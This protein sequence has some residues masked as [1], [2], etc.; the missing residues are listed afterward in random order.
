[1][2]SDADPGW[3][4]NADTARM[5]PGG[6]P[7]VPPVYGE[8]SAAEG[9]AAAGDTSAPA[10]RDSAAGSSAAVSGAPAAE[11]ADP[12]REA[13]QAALKSKPLGSSLGLTLDGGGDAE[14]SVVAAPS[15]AEMAAAAEREAA[16]RAPG[17]VQT[18][19]GGGLQGEVAT[20]S[21]YAIGASGEP[22]RVAAPARL[23]PRTSSGSA[24]S[25]AT[26]AIG[27]VI[28]GQLAVP[29]NSDLPGGAIGVVT[30]PVYDASLRHQVVPAGSW[31][32]GSYESTIAAGQGRLVLQWTAIRF[33]DGRTYELPALRA[34]DGTGASGIPGRVNN[35]YGRVFGQAL[36]TSVIAAGFTSRSGPADAEAS[37]RDALAQAAASQLGETAAQV[38]RRTLSIKPTITVPRLTPF[39]IILDRELTFLRP[40]P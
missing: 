30:R 37:R 27:T 29:I 24:Q 32:Y 11:S 28:D 16:T 8:G 40:S 1:M 10:A 13:Y 6:V 19:V 33:P 26:L 15:Y 18:D 39:T 23:P 9:A 38:T 5:L 2:A 21:S 12:R 14:P 36:L 7:P 31:L 25:S 34:G 35:H 20:P 3:M 4:R 22:P 17:A